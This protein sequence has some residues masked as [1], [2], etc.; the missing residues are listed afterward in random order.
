MACGIMLLLAA[1]VWWGCSW[2]PVPEAPKPR[3]GQTP[4][5]THAEVGSHTE[6]G[7]ADSRVVDDPWLAKL[8]PGVRV[9]AELL[10]GASFFELGPCGYSMTLPEENQAWGRILWRPDASRVLE[11]VFYRGTLSARV[12]SLLGLKL[13]DPMTFKRLLPA[14][15]SGPDSTFSSAGCMVY[16]TSMAE[17]LGRIEGGQPGES[18]QAMAE[19]ALEYFKR[20]VVA[21]NGF[22]ED[23]E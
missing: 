9:D 12:L 6:L 11:E 2:E 8:D 21:P 3:H 10:A 17:F 18:W 1:A 5:P 22:D 13:A 4:Q 20:D 7:G 23:E 19:T 15:E 16:E 14:L